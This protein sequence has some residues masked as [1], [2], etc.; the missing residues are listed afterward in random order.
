MSILLIGVAQACH[1]C[2]YCGDGVEQPW[3]ECD[4]G[5]NNGEYG[6]CNEDCTGLGPYC[7]D[8]NIDQPWEQCD[9]GNTEDDDGCSSNCEIEE[10]VCSVDSDCG[11]DS[12]AGG[13][14]YCY[15]GDVYQDYWVHKCINPGEPDAY[16]SVEIE[17]KLIEECDYDCENG[18]CIDEPEPECGNNILE[19]GEECDDG[20]TEDDDGC[21]SN[22]EIEEPVCSVDSDCG[23]DSCAGGPNYCYLGDV[24]QD[25]WFHK[26]INP[27]EFNA[28][29]SKSTLPKLIEECEYDCENGKCIDEPEPYCGDG[30]CNNDE[31]CSSCPEDCGECPP[32]P[33]CGDG[34]INQCWE[35]CDDGNTDDGDGCSSQCVIEYCGDG[36]INDVDEECDDGDDNGV[37][38]D[39]SEHSCTYCSSGCKLITLKKEKEKSSGHT[40]E[41]EQLCEPNWQCGGWSS[42]EEGTMTRNCYDTNYCEDSYNKPSEVASCEIIAKVLVEEEKSFP[43]GIFILIGL[44]TLVILIVVAFRLKR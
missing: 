35:K 1:Q 16:C 32:E 6:Y 4:D 19:E 29:C 31:T 17:P 41:I 13:P 37:K 38:C 21:S 11:T 36:I 40:S 42:C 23:I 28:Y 14:N 22:C 9:D 24:Y 27:G 10:P 43:Y 26:C 7:G 12:C 30:V 44:L 8:N 3:E 20:N 39:N 18:H 5:E 34:E 33:Y 15:E 2:P 25:Y